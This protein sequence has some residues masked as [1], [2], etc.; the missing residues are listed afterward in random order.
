MKI[1]LPYFIL[2]IL[3]QKDLWCQVL[4]KSRSLTEAGGG[5]NREPGS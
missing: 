2:K 5:R 4:W 1:S 3:N